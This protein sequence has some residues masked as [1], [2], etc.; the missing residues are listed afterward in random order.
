MNKYGNDG[1]YGE[2]NPPNNATHDMTARTKVIRTFDTGAT[3]DTEVGKMDYVGFES[4][5]VSQRFAEYMDLNRKQPDGTVRGSANWKNGIPQDAY[6]RSLAR[7]MKDLELHAEGFPNAAREDIESALCAIL[8]NARGMLF[9]ILKDKYNAENS[10]INIPTIWFPPTS[11]S[12][13]QSTTSGPLT[14]GSTVPWDP[15]GQHSSTAAPNQSISY[16]TTEKG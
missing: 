9:E 14:P 6:L 15:E 11:P 1:V 2:P 10:T 5:L 7:H 16:R 12:P 8:F 13:T 3:R 4:A